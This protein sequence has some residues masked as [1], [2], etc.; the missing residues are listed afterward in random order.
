MLDCQF[1]RIWEDMKNETINTNETAMVPS[2]S[3]LTMNTS[4]L[5]IVIAL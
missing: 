2:V 4:I 3:Y 1:T 5:I